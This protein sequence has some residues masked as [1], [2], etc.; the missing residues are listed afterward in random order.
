MIRTI[1]SYHCGNYLMCVILLVCCLLMWLMNLVCN[2]L[3]YTFC[4][5]KVVVY[6]YLLYSVY[7]GNG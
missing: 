6:I 1:S 4:S 5:L 3:Y 7:A 2:V